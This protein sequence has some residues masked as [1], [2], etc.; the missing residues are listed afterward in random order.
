MLPNKKYLGDIQIRQMFLSDIDTV[1]GLQRENNLS[2]WSFNDYIKQINDITS[3]NLIAS[4]NDKIVGFI[5]SGLII[6]QVSE[7]GNENEVEIFNFSVQKHLQ[8]RG[9]G[10]IILKEFIEQC[11]GF[12]VITI[13]LETRRSNAQAQNFYKKQ[14]FVK[15]YERKNY[16]QNP[17]EDAV[18]MRLRLNEI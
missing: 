2:F 3:I 14:G 16:Y 17:P 5:I 13:W 11:K 8:N 6:N 1:L 7:F 4:A 15:V 18:V 10:T 12:T 9:I